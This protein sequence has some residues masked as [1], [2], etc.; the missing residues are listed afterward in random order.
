MRIT[1]LG[2]NPVNQNYTNKQQNPA[3]KGTLI[4]ILEDLEKCPNFDEFLN[5]ICFGIMRKAKSTI[6]CY[7]KPY[8]AKGRKDVINFGELADE[9]VAGLVER[10]ETTPAEQIEGLTWTFTPSP[11]KSENPL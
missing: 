10:Y 8:G 5:A 1:S 6:A 4:G 3:F 7:T 11:E 2:Y 9:Y